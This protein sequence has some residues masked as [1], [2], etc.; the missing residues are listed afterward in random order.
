MPA[1]TPVLGITYPCGGDTINPAVF[2]TFTEG[3]QAALLT[4]D[5]A[6][7]AAANR[8]AAFVRAVPSSP[9][10]VVINTATTMTYQQEVWDNDGMADLAVNNDR[11]TI[12]TPGVYL[13]G[14]AA[15][16]FSGFATITSMSVTLT[17]N[18]VTVYRRKA[19]PADSG[20]GAAENHRVPLVLNAGDILRAQCRW[21]GTGG[22]ASVGARE[23]Q[24]ELVATL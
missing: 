1:S 2:A 10:S 19:K 12:Q 24:A 17:V 13:C 20:I 15:F 6:V 23:L 16:T 3:I 4:G 9:Q 5:A 11:L 14:A 22:P 18:G 7:A 8:P 21:T